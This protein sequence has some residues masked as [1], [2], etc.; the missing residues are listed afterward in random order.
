VTATIR[1]VLEE[2][3]LRA[4]DRA[5]LRLGL[6]RSA[7]IREALRE[8][9]KHLRSREKEQL[10]R[11]GYERTTDLEFAIWNAAAVWPDD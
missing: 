5:A 1:V 10:D 9:L 11:K 8:H 3:L 4:A 6:N 7:F 2:R